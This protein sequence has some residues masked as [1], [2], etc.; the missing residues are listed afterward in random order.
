MIL[1]PILIGSGFLIFS[2]YYFILLAKIFQISKLHGWISFFI[3][4]IVFIF[5][6]A[7]W[8]EM[9]K[10]FLKAMLGVAI[11]SGGIFLI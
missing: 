7:Y 11:I 3:P 1:A 4:V 2:V 6:A 5:I 10:S 9:G 8:D